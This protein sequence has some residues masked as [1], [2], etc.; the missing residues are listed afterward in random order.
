MLLAFMGIKDPSIWM[1]Y[2]LCILST[3]ACVVYGVMYWNKGA[4]DTTEEDKK[5][6][7]E[8]EEIEKE[9]E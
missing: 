5:W 8:E 9:F 4:A 7:L 6:A 2:L 3:I 1:A